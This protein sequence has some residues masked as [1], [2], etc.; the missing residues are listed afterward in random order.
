MPANKA[1]MLKALPTSLQWALIATV[2]SAITQGQYNSHIS[3]SK[4]ITN[5]Q[6]DAKTRE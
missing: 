1:P 2:K 4:V 3:S 5:R 6:S